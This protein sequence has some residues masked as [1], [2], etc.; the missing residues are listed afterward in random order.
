MYN[1]ADYTSMEKEAT[2]FSKYFCEKFDLASNIEQMWLDVKN[3][4]TKCIEKNVPC[5][6]VRQ[7]KGYPWITK[8]IRK[9]YRQRDRA[10]KKM[11]KYDCRLEDVNKFKTLKHIAQ[12]ETRRAHVNYISDLVAPD[13]NSSPKAF[14]SYMKHLRKDQSGISDLKHEGQTFADPIKKANILNQQFQ[15]VFTQDPD[16]NI[17]MSKSQQ[18][19]DMDDITITENGVNKLLG[20][21][22]EGKASGPDHIP[23]RILKRLKDELSPCITLLFNVSLTNGVV[24]ND[25]KTANVCPIYKK[26]RRSEASN[27]RPVSLTCILCKMLEH[28]I[29]SNVMKHCDKYNIL[30]K[31]QHGFRSKRSCETQLAGFVHD[32][33]S[34]LDKGKRSDCIILDFSKAF[35]KVSHPKLLAKLQCYGIKNSV[36]SWISSFLTGRTQ[37]VVL[38]NTFSD[39]VSVESGVPQGSVLGPVLFLLFI[40]DITS[41]I[42][43]HIRLF[44]DDCVLYREINSASDKVTLQ[45]DLDRLTNW[46]D[47]WK[48][49]FNVS[50]CNT[51]HVSRSRKRETNPYYMNG[52]QLENVKETKYLGVT[53]TED[54]KWD[55]H[56]NSIVNSANS[57]LGMLKRNLKKAPRKTKVAAYKSLVRP[58]VEYCSSIWDPYT[59]NNINKIEGVQRRSARYVCNNYKPRDSVTDMI[60]TLGWD[61]L[62]TRRRHNRLTLMYKI[63][64]GLVAIPPDD[65]LKPT[66]RMSRSSSSHT[67]QQYHCNTDQFKASFFPRTVVYWKEL[68]TVA[69][70]SSSV[71][72]FKNALLKP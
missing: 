45:E 10:F 53:I 23:S 20:N 62:Q 47:K 13:G 31:E 4:I 50:K 30:A 70:E 36:H 32:L 11:K 9:L 26:G 65:Y 25:W 52:Q 27:Y 38:N 40:N 15:S 16:T 2:N 21:L 22:K 43:S 66:T 69:V 6:M 49:L 8:R 39:S 44:A 60:S 35:D 19:P 59:S 54:L 68:P 57:M 17:D 12:R 48:M 14:F 51:L 41:N 37:Q 58:K 71:E 42:T 63:T 1:K 5:K 34:S 24:P 55:T 18:Y 46:A 61:P 3:F 64:N 67:Y 56:I 28:I 33:A 29:V 7:N 72:A